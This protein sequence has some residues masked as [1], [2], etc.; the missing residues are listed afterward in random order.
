MSAG[1]DSMIV[2]KTALAQLSNFTMQLTLVPALQP[3]YART[4][5]SHQY[6]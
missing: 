2:V 6:G 5:V 1:N 3:G 4:Q